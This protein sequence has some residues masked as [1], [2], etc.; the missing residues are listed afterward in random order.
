MG[1]RATL[2]RA[3]QR[4]TRSW[5]ALA[6]EL[7]RRDCRG[8]TLQMEVR[9]HGGDLGGGPDFLT[10]KEGDGGHEVV[11]ADPQV[12]A[13]PQG[14]RTSARC[15]LCTRMPQR[16]CSIHLNGTT[17]SSLIFSPPPRHGG[18]LPWPRERQ[19]M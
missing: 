6:R 1:V 9:G 8:Q 18:P 17:S 10:R 5:T 13:C 3:L 16:R 12:H 14:G 4:P 19:L 15:E 11:P 7:S 2:R